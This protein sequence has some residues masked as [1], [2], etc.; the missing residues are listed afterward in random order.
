MN[1]LKRRLIEADNNSAV[2]VGDLRRGTIS[3]KVKKPQFSEAFPE[4]SHQRR[5]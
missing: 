1:G 4:A 5:S 3:L 2:G